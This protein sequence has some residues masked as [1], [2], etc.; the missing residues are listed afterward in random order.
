MPS[1]QVQMKKTWIKARVAEWKIGF[2]FQSSS[3]SMDGWHLSLAGT[4]FRQTSSLLQI[5]NTKK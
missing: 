5:T 4:G 2:R 1:L 3:S